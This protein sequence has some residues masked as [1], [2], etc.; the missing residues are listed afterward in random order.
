[1]TDHDDLPRPRALELLLDH[2]GPESPLLHVDPDEPVERAVRAGL[3]GDPGFADRLVGELTAVL[4]EAGGD[5]HRLVTALRP[6]GPLPAGADWDG[7]ARYVRSLI[8]RITAGGP[9]FPEPEP[10]SGPTG[11]PV[12]IPPGLFAD[13][14]TGNG[15]ATEVLRRHEAQARAWFADPRGQLRLHLYAD[16]GRPVGTA[17]ELTARTAHTGDGPGDRA[18]SADRVGSEARTGP[19]LTGCVVLMRRDTATEQ[20]FVAS[21]YPERSLPE[22]VRARMPDLA[23]LFGG[24][25]GQDLHALDR[26]SWSAE[27]SL[28]ETISP[29]VRGSLIEQLDRLLAGDDDA[30]RVQVEALGSYV[31]PRR[32]RRWVKGLRRRMAELDWARGGR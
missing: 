18:G 21:S 28:N 32:L 11:L 13:L 16:L 17:G 25:F 29:A 24:Y 7:W 5:E 9:E 20:P 19:E 3:Q 22:Q 1:V 6:R 12:P 30:L 14:A 27:R 23:F 15:A 31:L 10:G 2:L 4:E 8:P 26:T